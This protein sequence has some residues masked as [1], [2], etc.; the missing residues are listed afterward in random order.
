M[1]ERFTI[2]IIVEEVAAQLR[3]GQPSSR[4]MYR[5]FRKGRWDGKGM[6]DPSSVASLI[7]GAVD[8]SAMALCS[9]YVA[10]RGTLQEQHAEMG[11][12]A[13]AL[14]SSSLEPHPAP[15]LEEPRWD[16]SSQPAAFH[17]DV[18]VGAPLHAADGDAELVAALTRR[19]RA[20]AEQA[21]ALRREAE[22][23]DHERHCEELRQEHARLQERHETAET[24]R[25]ERLAE[26]ELLERQLATGADDAAELRQEYLQRFELIARAGG[27]LWSRYCTGFERGYAAR[28]SRGSGVQPPR[29]GLQ[30]F[31]PAVLVEHAAEPTDSSPTLQEA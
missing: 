28:R 22:R 20:A 15:V 21:A 4:L 19:R 31:A 2:D 6:I 29:Q 14:R 24:G 11:A 23:L 25:L 5:F 17:E 18:A 1:F 3:T 27:L 16:E 9:E 12:R 7:T 30:F 10:R 26:A 8:L 13:A